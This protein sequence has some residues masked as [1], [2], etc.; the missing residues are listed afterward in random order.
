MFLHET[1]TTS[2]YWNE[3]EKTLD[4][5]SR[6]ALTLDTALTSFPKLL[7]NAWVDAHVDNRAVVDAWSRQGERSVS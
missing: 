6:E 7:R 5:S 4:I 2:G 1:V 3:E